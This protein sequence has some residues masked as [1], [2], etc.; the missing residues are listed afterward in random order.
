MIAD[1]SAGHR[2]GWHDGAMTAPH[3]SARLFDLIS[4]MMRTQTIAAI[5]EL[6][7][8]DAIAAGTTRTAELAREVGADPDALA[9]MLRLLEADGLVA[10]GAPGVWRLTETG[11]LL[12][13]DVDG[14]MRDLARLFASE[15]YEAWSGAVESL[16]SGEP[17]FPA[18]FGA[19]FFDWFQQH[20]EAARRFDRAMSGTAALRLRPL[21]EWDWSEV[22]TVVDVGGGNGALLEA[23]LGRFPLLT[24]ISFDLPQVAE[25]AAIRIGST[26]VAGRL[27]AEGGDFFHE[28]PRA[29]AYVLAQVLHD[30]NDE[31]SVR[32]LAACRRA[33]GD[34]SRLF[35]LEQTVPEG[36]QPSTVKL[37]DLNMLVLLGGR[38]RTLAEFEKLLAAGGWRLADH[39]DGPRSTLLAAVVA[40]P[41]T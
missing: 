34:G 18:R 2:Q 6:G 35:V 16:R 17:A 19:A 22:A 28:V 13:D 32:I 12:R 20:P 27:R 5:A 11:E 30:W 21:L 41:A 10:Q 4:G 38:E 7:V 39:R 9:R 8:A 25:R 37:L 15:L 40:G 1:P 24:G 23:L 31:D 33:A 3:P 29:D 14:S 36:D 26:P